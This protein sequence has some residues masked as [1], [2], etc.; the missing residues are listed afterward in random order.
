[1][2]K[3]TQLRINAKNIRKELDIK[4]ISRKLCI[5]M[6]CTDFYNTAKHVMLFY[7]LKY[8]I[9]TRELLDD[10]KK[11]YFPKVEGKNLLVCPY[12][13]EFVISEYNIYEPCSMPVNPEILDLIVVPALFVD[14]NNFR[15][16]YGG[17]FYDR[18]LKKYNNIISVSLLPAECCIQE[19]PHDKF[20]IPVKYVICI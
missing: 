9:D 6:R 19:L 11:F 20:D 14:K 2:D 4:L 7:P 16:G 15:L 5:K 3:K 12:T 17:G 8:E 18:F 10:D 1:M 13:S